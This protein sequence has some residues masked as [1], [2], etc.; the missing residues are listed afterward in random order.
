MTDS[1]K[2]GPKKTRTWVLIADRLADRSITVG[3]VLVIGAVLG[4]MVFLVHE[5]LPLF[6]GG[7]V[8]SSHVYQLQGKQEPAINLAMDEYKTIAV[9][10]SREGQVATWHVETGFP[11]EKRSFDLKDKTITAFAKTLDSSN[12]A[13]GFSDGT[14]RF[15]RIEFRND[16]LPEDQAPAGLKKI[17]ELY[18]T[19]GS[20]VYS[21]VPG[22]QIR[23]ISFKLELDDEIQVSES[24]SPIKVMDYR[25]TMFGERP[26]RI[27]L[28]MDGSGT[29][30]MSMTETKMNMF[31]RKVVT[32]TSKSSLPPIPDSSDVAFALVTEMADQAYFADKKGIIYRYNTRDF[33]HPFLAETVET[34]PQGTNLTV[35]GFL[36]G[37]ASLVVGGSDGS[38]S[39]YFLLAREG[40]K[41]L[42]GASLVRTR[43]FEPHNSAV[44]G[45]SPGQRG[46]TFATC[47]SKGEIWLRNGTSEETLVKIS[48]PEKSS[49]QAL[50]LAPRMNGILAFSSNGSS[51]FW[52][53]SVPHPEISLHTLFGKVWYEG[54]SEPGYTWQSSGATDAFEPKLSL[55]PLIFGTLKAT[56]YSLMFAIPI[57]LLGAIYTSEFLPARVR[58]KIKPVMEVMAS[59]PS[60]VLGFVAGL[61]LAP[62]VENWISAVL[63]VFLALPLLLVF[64]A[65]LWQLMPA[66]TAVRLEGLPKF[67]LMFVLVGFGFYLTYLG[68]PSFEKF[69]FNGN[70]QSWLNGEGSPAAFLFLMTVPLAAAAVSWS[71]SRFWGYRAYQYIRK[72]EMPYSALLDL[73]RW[74][75]IAGV[76]ALLSYVIAV[77]L[78]GVGFDPRGS[79]VGTYV[80]RNTLV[81]GFAMGFAVIPLI[82]TLAEDALNSVPDHLRAASLG[83]GATPWQTAIWIILPTALSG[84][85]SAVMIGMGRAVGETMIVVMSAGNTPLLDLNIFNGLRALSANIAV[86]LPEAPK[87]GTL[88]RVLFL[89]GLV[90]FGMTFVI[91]TVAELVRL[92]FRKRAMQL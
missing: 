85:F 57:A 50:V 70:F 11:L 79:I 81:V 71:F 34:M 65:Y 27:L 67:V 2:R 40:A 78:A 32:K 42:D 24:G 89:T 16:V 83:C 14:V 66:S 28:T 56:M 69:F 75:C 21:R 60:V 88:Y 13:V 9:S 64:S 37:E 12:I 45:F 8:E 47:D 26:K 82:Y 10:V 18:E 80:Q 59:I 74:L 72:M 43:K 39:I 30:T 84:V 3:G 63:L 38:L 62:V 68:G 36:M 86:E 53:L 33:E 17:N 7:S 46:K 92:R 51:G 90:L 23:K 61:V 76:T 58:G 48:P 22:R 19:D 55:V 52:D 87:D 54:Y 77:S 91:N 5:V 6:R 25:L 35:L 20:A 44:T 49:W 29:A 4:M 1:G 41:T 73:F 31:T 15:G